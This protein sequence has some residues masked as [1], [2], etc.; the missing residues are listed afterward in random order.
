MSLQPYKKLWHIAGWGIVILIL[1]LSIVPV[2]ADLG[3]EGGDKISHF[4]AYF[5]LMWW[6]AQVLPGSRYLSLALVCIG[7]GCALEIL[8]CFIEGRFCEF[9]DALANSAGVLTAWWLSK[10]WSIFPAQKNLGEGIHD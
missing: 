3:V 7:L 1:Y 4:A 5:V 10:I 6:F 9:A 2:P 8:Q